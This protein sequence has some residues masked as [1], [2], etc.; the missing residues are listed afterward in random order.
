MTQHWLFK[1]FLRLA[2]LTFPTD[3]SQCHILRFLYL[4]A[5]PAGDPVSDCYKAIGCAPGGSDETVI[6][7][8]DN[9][10]GFDSK[11]TEKLFGVFQRNRNILAN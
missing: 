6:F 1:S 3:D 11:Y 10:A 9:G 4:S 2:G 8:R 7:I 5:P